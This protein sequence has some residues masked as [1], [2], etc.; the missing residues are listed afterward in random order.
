M[1]TPR[2]T[3]GLLEALRAALGPVGVLT[4]SPDD[5]LE[6]Y[7]LDWRRRYQGQALAVVRPAD[8]AEVATVVQLCARYGASVVP[9][10]GNTSLV[11]GSVPDQSGTQIVLN[12]SRLNKVLGVDQANLSMTVQAG[13]LLADVQA[14]ADHAGL[15]FPLT[16]A[17]Q[18]SCTIGGNLASNAGG[19]QVLRYGTARELCLGLELVTP[20]GHIWHGLQGLRKDNTGYDLRH[21]M[22]GSEG[23]L[24]VITAATLRLFPRPRGQA[25]ALLACPDLDAA[26]ALL[27]A[28]RD[29]LDAGLTGCELM[30]RLP[31]E[32]V[33]Q[34]HPDVASVLVQ[35]GQAPGTELPAWAVLI[36]HTSCESDV[37]AQERL[38]ALLD[39]A[40][41]QGHVSHAVMASNQTQRQAMWHLRETIP[42]AERAHALM[43]KHDIGV[44]SSAIPRFVADCTQAIADRWP[45]ACVVCFGH[46]GDGNLHYNVQPPPACAAGA[47]LDAFELQVNELVFDH[48][49]RFGGTISAEHGIGVL[50][51]DELARRKSGVALS[52]MHAIKQ[53]LDPDGLMNP[54][55]VLR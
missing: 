38:G 24:G 8:S 10:G 14:A 46:M 21:L 26:L 22:V 48:V 19:T 23:T 45:Q 55:R 47:E 49:A 32:L 5:P 17:S 6:R 34:H 13:C 15:L 11:G 1:T 35:A 42:L 50:R 40:M 41:A 28:A 18:G 29:T 43:V 7:Q 30:G 2:D 33:R 16:L 36:E 12:L 25:T 53:A 3:A 54:G 9:Q 44:P 20:Q 52:M 27:Q 4:P 37:H 51:R 39:G 31:L